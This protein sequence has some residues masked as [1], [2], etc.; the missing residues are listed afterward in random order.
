MRLFLYSLFILTSCGKGGKVTT[1][2][3][4]L[5]IQKLHKTCTGGGTISIYQKSATASTAGYSG[6]GTI[7]L[8][9]SGLKL[10]I[11]G[12]PATIRF[13]CTGTGWTEAA[14]GNNVSPNERFTCN[15]GKVTFSPVYSTQISNP[16]PNPYSPPYPNPQ[17]SPT[18]KTSQ[19]DADIPQGGS[20][21]W[22]VGQGPTK[23]PSVNGTL[24]FQITA[25]RYIPLSCGT[26]FVCP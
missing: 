21:I 18:S 10:S 3:E 4:N 26:Q 12:C 20:E 5:G 9:G 8:K 22:L 6:V 23:K 7:T 2:T 14:F 15:G 11:P 24:Q 19:Y 16:Y 17:T 1:G 25:G 13:Q